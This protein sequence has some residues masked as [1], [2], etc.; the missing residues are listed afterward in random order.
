MVGGVRRGN[1][2]AQQASEA[3]SEAVGVRTVK[4]VA[5]VARKKR[6]HNPA[7]K[8][9]FKL[10]RYQYEFCLRLFGTYFKHYGVKF[11][12]RHRRWLY[13]DQV[14]RLKAEQYLA[15]LS[16][17]DVCPDVRQVADCKTCY[18]YKRCLEIFEIINNRADYSPNKTGDSGGKSYYSESPVLHGPARE[19]LRMF[20]PRL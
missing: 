11:D 12:E 17:F 15:F 3:R 9:D 7:A 20:D 16:V 18:D 4:A 1:R 19:V 5:P 8:P 2:A 13:Y 14:K 10:H 6:S